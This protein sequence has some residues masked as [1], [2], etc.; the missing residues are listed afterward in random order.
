M[1]TNHQEK[2]IEPLKALLRTV[3]FNPNDVTEA[4]RQLSIENQSSAVYQKLFARAYRE[5]RL[6]ADAMQIVSD[7]SSE[8]DKYGY[9]AL[10]V[11]SDARSKLEKDQ[12][13]YWEHSVQMARDGADVR[14]IAEY[15]R[16][17]G[18]Q[19]WDADTIARR[20]LATVARETTT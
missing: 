13:I 11:M 19:A 10:H 20:A 9:N 18:V 17:E 7:I 1:V 15:L 14:A 3:D 12:K 6:G 16:N 8:S 5:L 2:V 4:R